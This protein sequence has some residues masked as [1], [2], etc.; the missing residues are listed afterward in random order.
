MKTTYL[1]PFFIAGLLFISCSDD[2]NE[3][4]VMGTGQEA[5]I[6]FTFKL[7]PAMQGATTM[8]GGTRAE[9]PGNS[10]ENEIDG[11]MIYVYDQTGTPPSDPAKASFGPYSL[12]THFTQDVATGVYEMNNPVKTTDGTKHIYVVANSNTASPANDLGSF[13]NENMLLT[14][15]YDVHKTGTGGALINYNSTHAV[16]HIVFAGN[17]TET[18]QPSTTGITNEVTVEIERTVS[19]VITTCNSS[20]FTG[21]WT[22]GN[23]YNLS[24]INFLVKQDA[25][26]GVVG[27]NYYPG[28]TPLRK[29]TLISETAQAN[30]YDVVNPYTPSYYLPSG[31]GNN[32][33]DDY[34]AI[35]PDPGTDP[36]R[37]DVKGFYIG[38]NVTNTPNAE[39]QHGN[40]TY[41]WIQTRLA[42]DNTAVVGASGIEYTGTA[43]S[44][45]ETFH[46]VRVMGIRDYICR[47]ENSAAVAT[48]LHTQYPGDV[49]TYEFPYGYIYYRVF[50]NRVGPTGATLGADDK[51]NRIP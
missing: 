5:T 14:R 30:W 17:T 4:D 47:T 29:K 35:V 33:D 16:T 36:G 23:Y 6:K 11:V 31:A 19:R 12:S 24:I 3:T 13:G 49:S 2:T 1:F 34:V 39:A 45:T 26:K 50:L 51:Y 38:E 27:Q 37:V 22:A 43:L 20:A 10:V 46:L 7:P 44:G 18:L 9:I 15:I 41:A 42:L 25:Y 8:Q 21:E 32:I 40:T 48:Y 28:T